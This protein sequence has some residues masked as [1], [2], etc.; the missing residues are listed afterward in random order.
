MR[1]PFCQLMIE[2]EIQG[3]LKIR[4]LSLTEA[5]NSHAF[6]E[7]ECLLDEACY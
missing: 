3:I 1:I 5:L 6:L 4:G 7:L 2:T